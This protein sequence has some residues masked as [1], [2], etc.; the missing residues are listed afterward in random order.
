MRTRVQSPVPTQQARLP[1]TAITLVLR[2]CMGS[3][4]LCICTNKHTSTYLY[5]LSL[6]K[7]NMIKL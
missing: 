2:D 1:M 4:G 6:A 3:S 7:M 5:I